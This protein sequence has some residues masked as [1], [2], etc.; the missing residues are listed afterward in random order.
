MSKKHDKE[1][2]STE[3]MV[4]D[5]RQLLNGQFDREQYLVGD[6]VFV[7][8]TQPLYKGAPD[9]ILA[10]EFYGAITGHRL[11]LSGVE[12]GTA[13]FHKDLTEPEFKPK[14]K[15]EALNR[16]RA[17]L[18]KYLRGY[19]QQ[20]KAKRYSEVKV[21]AVPQVT[22]VNE[23]DPTDPKL[24]W[25]GRAGIV[26]LAGMRFRVTEE[27]NGNGKFPVVFVQGAPHGTELFGLTGCTTFVPVS[28]LRL[29]EFRSRLPEGGREKKAQERIWTCLHRI[30]T[31]AGLANDLVPEKKVAVVKPKPRVSFSVGDKEVRPPWVYGKVRA[32]QFGH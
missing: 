30:C 24:I 7:K 20:A 3:A 9:E 14:G 18:H 22:M 21:S 12:P 2:L 13:I 11:L 27:T 5:V 25:D 26:A 31:E 16:A 23:P 28:W 8:T 29:S 1:T 4:E 17:F 6:A 15:S 32:P 10:I 19:L